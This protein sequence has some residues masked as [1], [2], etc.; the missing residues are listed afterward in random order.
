MQRTANP[1]AGFC[2]R[3]AGAEAE[4][5]VFRARAQPDPI[6]RLGGAERGVAAL[7]ATFCC[8]SVSATSVPTRAPSRDSYFTASGV[9][10]LIPARCGSLPAG[11][12]VPTFRG[13]CP[14]HRR[15]S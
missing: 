4:G 1:S 7:E 11:V 15:L 5:A 10:G 8:C 13:V 2:L 12:A 6:A 9:S 3:V 14:M